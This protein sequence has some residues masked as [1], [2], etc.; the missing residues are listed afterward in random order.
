[1][2]QQGATIKSVA[3]VLGHCSLQTTSLYTK[4]D[5]PALTAVALPWMGGAP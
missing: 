2:L 3:D 1:M 5:F 4:L